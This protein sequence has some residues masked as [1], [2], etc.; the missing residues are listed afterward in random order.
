M[1]QAVSRRQFLRGDFSGRHV[2]LR[3]PWA[4]E[5]SLFVERCTGCDAC[6]DACPE[7]ILIH[8]KS[9]F[10]MVD[11]RRGEC[12]LCGKCHDVCES[13]ALQFTDGESPWLLIASIQMNC[14]AIQ[15][16]L[17]S[18]CLEQCENRAIRFEQRIGNAPY[19]K[20]D[21]QLCDGCGACYRICPADAIRM[22]YQDK[23]SYNR[24]I[25]ARR[26]R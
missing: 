4:I 20:L 23:Q 17:C 16:V 26:Q 10:P 5:E 24:D 13:Q 25:T 1:A 12:S 2:A 19:P 7:Q 11:F 14:L 15:G 21:P 22:Q 6:L 18:G 3:P 9:G 8:D